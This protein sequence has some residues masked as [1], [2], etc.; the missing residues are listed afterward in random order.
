MNMLKGKVAVVTG[1]SRGIGRATAE[2]LAQEGAAVVGNYMFLATMT[3]DACRDFIEMTPLHR[4][5]Q[6]E[7]IADVIVFLVSDRARWVT[8]QNIAA[9][10]GI[11]SR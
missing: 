8:R 1:A 7:E 3:P 4:L 5:G 2:R 11:I 9:D 10:G 6:P